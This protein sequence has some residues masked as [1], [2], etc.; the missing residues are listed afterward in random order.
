MPLSPAIEFLAA[1]KAPQGSDL[2]APGGAQVTAIIPGNTRVALTVTPPAR[3]YA[4]Y[5]FRAMLDEAV[6]PDTL[7]LT[8]VNRGVL[9]YTGVL[10]ASTRGT[11]LDFFMAV[12]HANPVL[13][14]IENISPLNQWFILY[15]QYLTVATEADFNNLKE[16]LAQYFHQLER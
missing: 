16:R 9:A 7:T 1:Q 5:V 14:E 6:V 11:Y 8:M 3:I 12:T 4:L 2:T 15:T 13:Y 10:R